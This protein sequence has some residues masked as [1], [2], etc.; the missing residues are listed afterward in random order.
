MSP[1]QSLEPGPE[2]NRA[3]HHMSLIPAWINRGVASQIPEPR[4]LFAI[5]ATSAICYLPLFVLPWII[6]ALVAGRGMSDVQ[7]GALGTVTSMS[8]AAALIFTGMLVSRLPPRATVVSG[9]LLVLASHMVLI[10]ETGTA[11]LIGGLVIF[12]IGCG[13]CGAIGT[14]LISRAEHPIRISGN[15]WALLAVTQG[16]IW[17]IVPQFA[18][19]SGSTGIFTATL[20]F[21]LLLG[22]MLLLVP[23]D[24]AKAQNSAGE[25]SA[26]GMP[27]PAGLLIG[28]L[29]LLVIAFWLRDGIVWSLADRRATLLG[30]SPEALSMT[31][32]GTSA[33]GFVGAT[34]A[35]QL[36]GRVRLSVN[37]LTSLALIGIV[38]FAITG[39]TSRGAYLGAILFWTG[40][41]LFAWAYIL[42]I[43]ARLD[44][45]GRTVAIASGL[46]LATGAL[47]PLAGGFLLQHV[48]GSLL[49]PVVFV[50]SLVT[51][52]AALPIVRRT[53]GQNTDDESTD[54]ETTGRAPVSQ[55]RQVP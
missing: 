25:S 14:S 38:M 41:S 53:A 6:S 12:A 40:T 23:P 52:I 1:D 30:V 44:I 49:Q 34:L 54:E 42:G 13:I 31:L 37:V 18:A 15:M 24:R 3:L 5:F 10:R 35:A 9:G 51:L 26:S 55:D 36:E 4:L 8:Q 7:A 43:A 47:G 20:C 50:L 11:M 39:A 48:N 32:L 21:I 28:S 19:G 2:P 46:A 17:T 33:V 22:P 45:T 29:L 27:V 16:L